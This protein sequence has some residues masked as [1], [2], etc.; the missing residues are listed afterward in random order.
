MTAAGTDTTHTV[1][2]EDKSMNNWFRKSPIQRQRWGDKQLMPHVNWGDLF[3]DLFY[4]VSNIYCSY[5]YNKAEQGVF[6]GLLNKTLI[7]PCFQVFMCLFFY[8]SLH[9]SILTIYLVH[10]YLKPNLP[11]VSFFLPPV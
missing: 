7:Q 4:V 9:L 5:I 2:I 11:P 3:F 8:H 6:L 10:N 1:L